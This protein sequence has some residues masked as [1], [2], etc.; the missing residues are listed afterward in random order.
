MNTNVTDF[1]LQPRVTVNGQPFREMA[2][3]YPT[4]QVLISIRLVEWRE[5][6]CC[7]SSGLKA[8]RVC[9]HKNN[10]MMMAFHPPT[11]HEVIVTLKVFLLTLKSFSSI[12]S[13]N[14]GNMFSL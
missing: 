13:R 11:I 10:K 7:T 9:S 3:H 12:L 2:Y 14:Q 8:K 6:K 4:S 5:Y 1:K